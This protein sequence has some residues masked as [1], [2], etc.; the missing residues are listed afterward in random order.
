M[1]SKRK[2]SIRF[3]SCPAGCGQHIATHNVN[4][5]LDICFDRSNSQQKKNCRASS[6]ALESKSETVCE[7]NTDVIETQNLLKSSKQDTEIKYTLFAEKPQASPVSEPASTAE[8]SS[9]QKSGHQSSTSKAETMVSPSRFQLPAQTNT[10]DQPAITSANASFSGTDCPLSLPN[11]QTIVSPSQPS[12][13]KGKKVEEQ[14]Q[15]EPFYNLDA[16]V[17]TTSQETPTTKVDFSSNCKTHNDATDSAEQSTPDSTRVVNEGWATH[18]L[19]QN[20]TDIKGGSMMN[21]RALETTVCTSLVVPSPSKRIPQTLVSRGAESN[22][23][24]ASADSPNSPYH[25]TL[26]H[27]KYCPD[28]KADSITQNDESFSVE[29]AFPETQENSTNTPLSKKQI[30]SG[31]LTP[32]DAPSTM[33]A[34]GG[35]Q[36]GNAEDFEPAK[37]CQLFAHM[38]SQSK[39]VFGT[40]QEGECWFWYTEEGVSIQPTAFDA[41]VP[42]WTATIKLR[43]GPR[44]H[45]A[46]DLPPATSKR[47]YVQG[48]SRL[49]V[50]V[51]KSILQKSIRRR[52]PLPSVRVALELA[53]KSLGDLLRRLPVM[54]LEDSTLHPDIGILVWL[55]MAQSKDYE[56][57]PISMEHVFRIVFEIAS[58]RWQDHLEAGEERDSALFSDVT[59]ELE[60]ADKNDHSASQ[61]QPRTNLLVCVWATMARASYGG[62]H[63]DVR[64]L[65]KFA[66]LWLHRL[67][68]PAIQFDHISAGLS[69]AVNDHCAWWEIP[70]VLHCRARGQCTSTSSL[71]L[72]L[73]RSGIDFLRFSDISVEG[74]DFHCSAVIDHLIK[75]EELVQLSADLLILSNESN[76]PSS[77]DEGQREWLSR[78]WKSCM[79]NYC[80]GTNHRRP[81]LKSSSANNDASGTK[82]YEHLWKS[83][84]AAKAL[85]FQKNYVRGRLHAP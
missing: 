69:G 42:V 12:C 34:K 22:P 23:Q 58:C 72:D 55:M 36:E 20:Q 44:V 39:K 6:N 27:T 73:V 33:N 59:T 70:H 82:K 79:W 38:M 4:R 2:S 29:V 41:R 56:P 51:L 68:H 40:K 64:M 26:L 11:S 17:P 85:E 65:H 3:V 80:S 78:V 76:F 32:S 81:L 35:T 14:R 84:V 83:L 61:K 25:T 46:T 74:V 66:A 18:L 21:Q 8:Q 48:H 7:A 53:D 19:D 16:T 30:I 13:S 1:T 43:D 62:M 37:P 63:G 54:I 60:K 67:R 24:A 15:Q 9:P 45:L 47:R 57:P 71:F 75:D 52:K 5:H 77:S 10:T 31:H 28:T 49:S 50:P